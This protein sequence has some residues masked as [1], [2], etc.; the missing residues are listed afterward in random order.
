MKSSVEVNIRA[1]IKDKKSAY[2]IWQELSSFGNKLQEGQDILIYFQFHRIVFEKQ[3]TLLQ[4]FERME[5]AHNKCKLAKVEVPEW[6][7]CLMC[8]AKLPEESNTFQRVFL[9]SKELILLRV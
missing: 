9:V 4:F 3:E 1:R 7:F 2:E 6:L 8:L 5:T